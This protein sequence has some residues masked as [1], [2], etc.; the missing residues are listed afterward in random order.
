MNREFWREWELAPPHQRMAMIKRFFGV[1][2]SIIREGMEQEYL[3]AVNN[4]LADLWIVKN[5]EQKFYYTEGIKRL[6]EIKKGEGLEWKNDIFETDKEHYS[7][8]EYDE[9]DSQIL[10]KINNPGDIE[11]DL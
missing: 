4:I 6:N 1:D 2:T 7:G 11:D 3:E 9:D 10:D 8:D 5:Q